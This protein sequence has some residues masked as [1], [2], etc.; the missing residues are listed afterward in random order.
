MRIVFFFFL[1]FPMNGIVEFFFLGDGSTDGRT[2]NQSWNKEL[3]FIFLRSTSDW[4]VNKLRY[5]VTRTTTI[6]NIIKDDALNDD[7]CVLLLHLN[8][9]VRVRR[10]LRGNFS[11][12]VRLSSKLFKTS[13]KSFGAF[14][15]LALISK[16]RV[17][18]REIVSGATTNIFET[19]LRKTRPSFF[20]FFFLNRNYS[21]RVTDRRE[22]KS[23]S[24]FDNAETLTFSFV[25]SVPIRSSYESVDAC[26]STRIY[27][28]V[29]KPETVAISKVTA[30]AS[31][32]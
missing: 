26:S 9:A 4:F 5:K 28:P 30:N 2:H 7:A 11:R 14:N 17:C 13:L 8:F 20:F 15:A 31:I 23:F 29:I 16:C 10:R 19:L 27:L 21:V 1:Q 24:S 6:W 25:R 18:A 22:R 3:Y 32:W 12:L